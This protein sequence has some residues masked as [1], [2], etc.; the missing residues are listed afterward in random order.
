MLNPVID[1]LQTCFTIPTYVQFSYSTLKRYIHNS[2]CSIIQQP[3]QLN[4][5]TPPH[6]L[7]EHKN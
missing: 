4:Q 1:R 6:F 2:T 3:Y 5:K 7:E